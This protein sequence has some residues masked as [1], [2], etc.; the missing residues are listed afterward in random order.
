MRNYRKPLRVLGLAGLALLP[1][2]A[3]AWRGGGFGGGPRRGRRL[4]L[5]ASRRLWRRRLW[6]GLSRRL[7]G[8]DPR[9]LRRRDPRRLRRRLSCRLWRRRLLSPRLRGA[10]VCWGCVSGY[11]AGAVARPASSAWPPA[12]PSAQRASS[13]TWWCNSRSMSR[14]PPSAAR[15]SPCP[16][17]AAPASAPSGVRYY[18]C[19]SAYYQPHFGSN[20]VYYTVVANPF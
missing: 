7:R 9:R 11:S 16:A 4:H 10:A 15:C 6:R 5:L 12:R 20:G 13:P 8:R 17:A 3:Q 1:L 2:Q 14:D 18:N 19:G